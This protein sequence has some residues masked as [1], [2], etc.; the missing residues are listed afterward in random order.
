MSN[1][2]TVMDHIFK[3]EGGYSNHP[4]DSGGA[5]N[6][7][8]TAATLAAH[9]KVK[10]VTADDVKSLTKEEAT[11]IYDSRYWDRMS[12][13]LVSNWK[14]QMAIMDQGV[15]R[16]VGTAVRMAQVLANTQFKAGLTVDDDLGPK[17]AKFLNSVDRET[18]V[19]E[20]IQQ[21][22]LGYWDI[23]T[24]KPDQSVFFKGWLNRTHIL[25]DLLWEGVA[26]SEPIIVPKP[27]E[28]IVVPGRGKPYSAYE[29]ALKELGVAEISGSKDNSRIVWY[30]GFTMLKATD[31]ETPWCSSFICAAAASNGCKSTKSAAAKSWLEMPE[32]DGSV[33]DLAVY[34]RTGGHHVHFVNRKY[35]SK[36]STIQGVGGN[37]GNKVSIAEYNKANLLG[38]RKLVAA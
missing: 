1:Q 26:T 6:L 24:R 11:E 30:H 38:F 20:Y 5:T 35:S 23:V 17:T 29:W 32:G 18:F 19:R 13:D 21:A 2:S 3:V 22:Q 16:G 12:L 4:K 9:R 8:I 27:D 7:G 36:A 28:S 25:Q 34:K 15:N 10:S 37:Q 33:G 14:L 31:D